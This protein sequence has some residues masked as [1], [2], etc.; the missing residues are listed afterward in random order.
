MEGSVY[1]C[2]QLQAESTPAKYTS[3]KMHSATCSSS[4]PRSL[5]DQG[6]H[7]CFPL[8]DTLIF[9]WHPHSHNQPSCWRTEFYFP[10]AA[11]RR[12]TRLQGH[13]PH[14]KGQGTLPLPST[15][16]PVSVHAGKDAHRHKQLSST[17]GSKERPAKQ[18]HCQ[19]SHD[20]S[21]F[22]ALFSLIYDVSAMESIW[23]QRAV[24][25]CTCSH[26]QLSGSS[27]SALSCADQSWKTKGYLFSIACLCLLFFN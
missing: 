26:E 1:R 16:A 14:C 19:S 3:D 23:F 8:Q 17:L 20:I 27:R 6:S 13:R 21:S 25:S 4:L 7:I 24:M 12:E 22:F 10:L 5:P 9:L 18:N 15:L 11:S 2:M